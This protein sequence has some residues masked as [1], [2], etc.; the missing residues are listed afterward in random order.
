MPESTSDTLGLIAGSGSFPCDIAR[1]ASLRG[2]EVAVIAFH[3]HTDPRLA[4]FAHS[5][6]WV[7]P[8]AVEVALEALLATGVRRAVMAGKVPKSVLFRDGEAKLD[9][10]ASRE[11]GSLAN[12]SDD[13]ILGLVA[14]GLAK[15]GVELLSQ[16]ELVPELVGGVGALG[17]VGLSASQRDD[18]EFAWSIAKT[19][20]GLDIG[21]T[22]V[23]KD[24]AVLAVEAIEGTDAAIRR[25]GAHTKGARVVKVAKPRQD[26]RFDV[27]AIGLETVHALIDAGADALAFEA[28]RTVV[29]ERAR[30]VEAADREG[31][32]LVGIE[33]DANAREAA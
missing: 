21:Q 19:F 24:G 15:V 13:A 9:A 20:A 4:E 11:L 6:T 31:I 1:S 12:L 2:T 10:R 17:R 30:L 33:S 29:L 3:G 23:V 22:V 18:V 26:P 16:L 27:P 14:D 25:A 5:V 28:G 8:G 32:A 7:H